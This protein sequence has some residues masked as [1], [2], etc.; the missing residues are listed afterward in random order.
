MPPPEP[1]R[2]AAVMYRELLTGPRYAP[3]GGATTRRLEAARATL[4]R[5]PTRRRMIR[6]LA[7][8]SGGTDA[9]SKGARNARRIEPPSRK[10][11]IAKTGEATFDA[12]DMGA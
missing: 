3:A 9:V 5:T 2:S 8:R 7:P 11:G 6:T 1:A 10:M 12:P 4:A